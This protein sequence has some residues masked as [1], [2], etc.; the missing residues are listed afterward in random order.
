MECRLCERRLETTAR[1]R[2]WRRSRHSALYSLRPGRPLEL[3]ITG[4]TLVPRDAQ[5]LSYTFLPEGEPTKV[6][7]PI[8]GTGADGSATWQFRVGLLGGSDVDWGKLDPSEVDR[9]VQARHAQIRTFAITRG[10]KEPVTSAVGS[11]VQPMKALD[12]CVDHLVT[13]WGLDPAK[14]KSLKS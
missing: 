12:T 10:F 11:V 6:E 1:V 2:D 7:S 8:Y 9:A 3:L 4:R 5:L 14:Q 13:S